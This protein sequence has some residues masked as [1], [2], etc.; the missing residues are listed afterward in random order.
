[1]ATPKRTNAAQQQTM[2]NGMRMLPQVPT[3]DQ[4]GDGNPPFEILIKISK[5]I[6]DRYFFKE[7][8]GNKNVDF[9]EMKT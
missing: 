9:D 2:S 4:C 6:R 5:S 7:S 1:M 8:F 3:A